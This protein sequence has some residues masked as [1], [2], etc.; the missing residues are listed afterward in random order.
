MEFNRIGR[1]GTSMTDKSWF[2]DQISLSKN[3][4]KQNYQTVTGPN[5]TESIKD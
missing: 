4:I 2:L 3:K 1:P 5:L